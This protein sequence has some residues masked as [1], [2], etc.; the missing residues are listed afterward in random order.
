M[1]D[2]VDGV[3]AAIDSAVRDSEVSADAMRSGPGLPNR[4]HPVEIR[5][6]VARPTGMPTWAGSGQAEWPSVSV[7]ER[8]A[9][10]LAGWD[11]WNDRCVEAIRRFGEAMAV[12]INGTLG[13][14]VERLKAACLH[15]D[16]PADPRQR[17]LDVQQNRNT[18]P[19]RP[20]GQ[21]ARRPR[22]VG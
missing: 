4:P 21:S 11:D 8:L 10:V 6:D 3:L 19:T 2:G 1:A 17:A 15:H 5:W 13:P 18:G 7:S 12:A 22:Q 9:E 16:P 20:S 14:T